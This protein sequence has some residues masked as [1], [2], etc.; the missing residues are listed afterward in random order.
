MTT[1]IVRWP[2]EQSDNAKKSY[3][4]FGISSSVSDST[5]IS[6]WLAR[7]EALERKKQIQRRKRLNA[8][9]VLT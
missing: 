1:M 9:L 3:E 2:G 5:I 4:E 7:R 8:G 6:P